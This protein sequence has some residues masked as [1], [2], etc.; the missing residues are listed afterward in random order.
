MD[1]HHFVVESTPSAADTQFLEDRLYEY[2]AE[3]TG[4]DDGQW[5]AIY[6]RDDQQAIQAGIKRLD[7]V[8]QLLY[9]HCM[10]S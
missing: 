8:W 5:L 9:Q 3:Q 4:V 10:G 2:N 6:V 1:T 7:L